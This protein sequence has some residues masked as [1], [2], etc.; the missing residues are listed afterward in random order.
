MEQQKKNRGLYWLM[1]F[2]STAGL[3]FAIYSHWS[4]LT[5]IL[6][7]VTTSFVKAMDIM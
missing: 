4:W 3:I 1:F 6:P 2:V 7:F 5:L